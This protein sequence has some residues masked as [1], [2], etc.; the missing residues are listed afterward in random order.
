LAFTI[1]YESDAARFRAHV[2]SFLAERE[3]EN[4]LPLALTAGIADNLQTYSEEAP[5][6]ASVESESGIEV[7]AIMT[8]PRNLVISTSRDDAALSF[9][10]AALHDAK[11][12]LPGVIGREQ[13]VAPFAR[14]WCELT[15]TNSRRYMSERIYRLDSVIDP[16]PVAGRLRQCDES[17]LPIVVPWLDGFG[18][19]TGQPIGNP[20]SFFAGPDRALFF[21]VD[22]EPVTMAGAM[23]PT[24]NGRRVGAVYTPPEF[25]RRGYASACVA[26]LSRHLLSEG[27]KFCFLFTDL[28]NRTTNHIYQEIGYRPVCDAAEIHFER[29]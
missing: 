23:A 19:D 25:R 26:A 22:Q 7:V 3:A 16:P 11:Y 20:K 17:D 14:A 6:L 21:W 8:P 15:G 1:K 9:L 18:H 13:D 28:D 2:Q 5:L 12:Q 24:P 4:N 27:R 29:A 10:A